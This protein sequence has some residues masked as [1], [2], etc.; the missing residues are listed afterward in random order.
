[1]T[2][3]PNSI[4][5]FASSIVCV[6][7]VAG[8]CYL[9]SEI[10]GYRSIALILLLTVSILAMR[11]SLY[12]VLLAALLSALIWDYFFIPPH[13]T[14]HINSYEDALMLA[15]YFIVALLNGVLTARIRFFEKIAREKQAKTQTLE[16]Y[17]TLFDALSHELRTPIATILGASDHLLSGAPNLDEKGKNTLML[18]INK[19]SER[20]NYLTENLLNM[21]RLE[22]GFIQPKADWCD[23]SELV[24]MVV[25][26]LE[27]VLHKHR[28]QVDIPDNLPLVKLDF[29]LMEQVL[30]NLLLNAAKHT[31]E[32]SRIFIAA[33]A[34]NQECIIEISD[35]GNG[36]NAADLPHIFEKFY[37]TRNTGAGGLGLGLSIVKGF[38]EAQGGSISVESLPGSGAHF[39]I[40][41][42]VELNYLKPENED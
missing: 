40:R 38:V 2:S 13:Y 9:F 5:Q 6:I 14:F 18:E 35:S 30:Q 31:P 34:L 7:S 17:D 16:L 32:G 23:V 28:V 22:S 37:R 3:R 12:P 26:R 29:G 15:M 1:M 27:E 36:F 42:P 11:L 4:R 10:I 8:A 19:A 33:N 20:L 25:N 24:Y 41:I 39:R 21:S